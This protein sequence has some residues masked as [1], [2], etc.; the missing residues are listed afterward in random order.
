MGEHCEFHPAAESI[1]RR[2]SDPVYSKAHSPDRQHAVVIGASV[3]G[4]VA[5]RALSTPFRSVTL[6]DRDEEPAQPTPR[7]G[8]PQ[9]RHVHVVLPGGVRALDRLF[10]GRLHELVRAGSQPFDYGQSQFH[11][12]GRWMP[13]IDTELYTLAQTRPLLEE[14]LRRWV[15]E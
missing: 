7:A 1:E 4:L 14:H 12:C 5:A 15:G 13:R 2:E 10:P 3:A 8:V 6:L 9:G 11:M